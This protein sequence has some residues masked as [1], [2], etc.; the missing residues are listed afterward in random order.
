MEAVNS[1]DYQSVQ[2]LLRGGAVV[3]KTDESG[4]TAL[5]YAATRGNI[6]LCKLLIEYKANVGAENLEGAL[7]YFY[8]AQYNHQDVCEY[9]IDT[10]GSVN[11]LTRT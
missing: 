6:E 9:L 10:L 2:N 3:D 4:R 8:A 7:P 1:E 11:H 5:F